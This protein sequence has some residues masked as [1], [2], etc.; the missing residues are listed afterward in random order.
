[1]SIQLLWL[2]FQGLMSSISNLK[3]I[4]QHETYIMQP[5]HVPDVSKNVY[6]QF[7]IKQQSERRKMLSLLSV[8]MVYLSSGG[9]TGAKFP[10]QF[11]KNGQAKKRPYHSL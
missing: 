10:G 2:F 5:R 6:K 9:Q 8:I 7:I 11:L 1:M 4:L 3:S